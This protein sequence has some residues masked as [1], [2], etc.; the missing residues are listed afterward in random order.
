[1]NYSHV[2]VSQQQGR[3]EQVSWPSHLPDLNFFLW[4]Y[5]TNLLYASVVD[6]AEELLQH[7]ENGSTLAGIFQNINQSMCQAEASA[8]VQDQYFEHLM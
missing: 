8:T 2:K 4:E 1:M 6:T 7:D 3:Q 5:Q